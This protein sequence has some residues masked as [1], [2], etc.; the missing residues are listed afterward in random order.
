MIH[1]LS[2]KSYKFVIGL[3]LFAMFF[4]SGNLIFPLSI[5][6]FSQDLWGWGTLGFLLTGALLPF[7]GII[8]MVVYEGDY[9]RFFSVL[10]RKGGFLFVFLLLSAWIPFGSGPRCLVLSYVNIQPYLFGM[11]L[12][13]YSIIYCAILYIIVYKKSTALDILGYFLTPLLLICLA[14]VIYLG[15]AASPGTSITH[16]TSSTVFFYGLLE[17]YQ[18]QDLIASFFFASAVMEI[19]RNNKYFTIIIFTLAESRIKSV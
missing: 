19:I 1:S 3:A 8:A 17:G 10:G 7:L 4:G 12:W 15:I 6:F 16:E 11:P 14:A 2:S 18:T 13:T 9:E 5:G